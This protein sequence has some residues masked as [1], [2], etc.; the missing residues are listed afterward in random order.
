MAAA[1]RFW[2]DVEGRGGHAAI[3][4]LSIDPVVAAAHAVLALQ[5]LVSRET[6]AT[7]SAVVTV[8]R[9]NTG[10][11]HASAHAARDSTHACARSNTYAGALLLIQ[12]SRVWPV[13]AAAAQLRACRV[14]HVSMHTCGHTAPAL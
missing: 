4:H 10:D 6:S 1:D 8:A 9:F 11:S 3:P 14:E 2:A 12:G 7:D 13:H 5:P